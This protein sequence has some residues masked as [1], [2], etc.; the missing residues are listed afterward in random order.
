MSVVEVAMLPASVADDVDLVDALCRVV[1]SA[2]ES[3]EVGVWRGTYLR[4]SV[5]ELSAA[6][7]AGLVAV[8]RVDGRVVGS[9]C[10]R[11]LDVTT[12]WFGMLAVDPSLGGQG[13]GRKLVAFAER[14][15]MSAGMTQMQLELLAPIEVDIAHL[16]LLA[17]WYQRLGY[18]EVA[19]AS[20][21]DNEPEAVPFLA[22]PCQIVV[23]VKPLA[24]DAPQPRARSL[25][26]TSITPG[27]SRPAQGPL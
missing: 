12:G 15:S 23:Q 4:T 2:Y 3:A 6:V 1:N 8:A 21:A 20:L 17:Q 7:R 25:P 10:M 16:R 18:R 11:Q 9:I 5:T 13:L 22:V 26:S 24:P 27:A 19:R 14:R